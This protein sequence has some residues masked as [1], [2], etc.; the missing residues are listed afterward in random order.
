PGAELRAPMAIAVIG[1]VF[2]STLLTLFVVPCV[3][4]LLSRF[5][6]SRVASAKREK[7]IAQATKETG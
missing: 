5:E 7:E 2:V 6:G 3:Y 4:E 1:G